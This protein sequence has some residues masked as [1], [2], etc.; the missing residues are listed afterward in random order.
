MKL[1]DTQLVL[2]SAASQRNDR[3]VELPP[4]L[5][6]RAAQK[7]I[8][9]LLIGG[10]LEETP[11]RPG[12]P[13]WRKDEQDR[14]VSL[15]VTKQGLAAI[16]VQDDEAVA[17]RPSRSGPESGRP[18]RPK[19]NTTSRQKADRPKEQS[20]QSAVIALLSRPHGVNIA[21]IMKATG[22]QQHSVRGFLTAV[23]RKKLK[24]NLQSEKHGSQ[25][26]YRILSRRPA[27][28]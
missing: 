6:G 9:K 1:T 10:L 26:V 2:L 19:N 7:V 24:L 8:G 25:R 22:W 15:L 14:P 23:V 28:A 11:A 3:V 5:K 17:D 12:T 27:A 4:N 20:K 18:K 13:V 21:A 16:R